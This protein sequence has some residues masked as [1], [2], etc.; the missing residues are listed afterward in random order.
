MSS[1]PSTDPAERPAPPRRRTTS[2]ALSAAYVPVVTCVTAL[3]LLM[4]YTATGAAGE[5]PARISVSNARIFVSSNSVNTA[6]FFDIT[7]TGPTGDV[8][9]SVSSAELGSTM[10][11]RRVT[12]DGAGRMEALPSLTIPARS[13]VTMS[14]YGVDVMVLDPPKLKVGDVVRFDLWFLGSGRVSVDAVVVPPQM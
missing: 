6:A 11:G 3:M 13:R 9:K 1:A 7:N 5:P 2:G 12:E 14:P 10:L 4:A 8:L